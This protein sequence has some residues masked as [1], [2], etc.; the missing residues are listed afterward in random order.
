VLTLRRLRLARRDERGFTLVETLVAMVC[1]LVV[2]A[3]LFAILE[4]SLH[5]TARLTDV[6][7]ASQ[8]GRTTMTRIVDELHSA[9]IAPG[10][11]G[12]TPVQEGSNANE[13]IVIDAYGANAEI[14]TAREDKIVYNASTKT[15][16]DYSRVSSAESVW[17]KFTFTA[18]WPSTG[19]IIGEGVTQTENTSKAA[20]PI[21]TYYSYA[22]AANASSTSAS[23]A[24]N[25][26][27]PLTGT[28]KKETAETVASVLVSFRTAPTAGAGAGSRAIQTEAN[29]DFSSQVTFAFSAP[30]SETTI[31]DGPC[32]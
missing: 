32:R 7:Q 13:L 20:I 28:L 14:T 17:P 25:E 23:S 21:F 24:L 22:T 30:G 15:L 31:V 6:A 2:S 4:V 3:A 18:A 8:L 9:C 19:T 27:E 1:G 29:S 5:Q 26:S 16:T 12:Y 10:S 11:T